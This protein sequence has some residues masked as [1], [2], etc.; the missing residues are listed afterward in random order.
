MNALINSGLQ[1]GSTITE[2]EI[3]ELQSSDEENLA[4]AYVVRL[5]SRSMKTQSECVQKLK[6]KGYTESAIDFAIN[7]AIEYRYLDDEYYT[8]CFIT[9]R[10][11]PNKWGEQK[12]I[13]ELQRKGVDKDIIRTKI[14]LLL[15]REQSLA[16]AMALACV[17]ISSISKFPRR[18]QRE[19]LYTFLRGRGFSNDVIVEVIDA[20]ITDEDSFFE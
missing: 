11:I 14:D 20:T 12:I 8:D 19:K 6:L 2:E 18:K 4:Y 7:K 3:E 5:I 10:A 15:S 17:K 16:S 1:K 13:S 9:T